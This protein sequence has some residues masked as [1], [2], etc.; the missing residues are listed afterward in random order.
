MSRR[1]SCQSPEFSNVYYD[2]QGSRGKDK[3][4]K[5]LDCTRVTST[6]VTAMKAA[7]RVNITSEL[8]LQL[9]ILML[10]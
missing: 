8:L 6:Y 7:K 9:I 3:S 2:Q 10:T 4:I 1:Q 5:N